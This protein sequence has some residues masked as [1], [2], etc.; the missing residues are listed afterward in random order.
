[1]RLI[2]LALSFAFVSMLNACAPQAPVAT[3]IAWRHDDVED[4]FAEAEASGKP[5]LLYWGAEW[6]PPCNRLKAGLFQDAAFIAQ[7]QGFVPVYLDGDSR[8]AQLYG[9]QFAIQGYATFVILRADRS[10]ITRLAGGGDSDRIS[11]ALAAAQA[12]RATVTE[13]V[14][15]AASAPSQLSA[16]DW[17]LI[18]EYGWEID[19][20]RIVPEDQRAE[21]LQ[22]LAAAAPNPDLSRRFELLA[23]AETDEDQTLTPAQQARA[24]ALLEV[25]LANARETRANRELLIYSG[26]D[27][28]QR[29]AEADRTP[30][31]AALFAALDDV[32]AAND[33]PISDRIDAINAE[34]E[35]FRDN[36]ATP[37]TIAPPALLA[38]VR[39]RAAW[40]DAA[41]Q[42]PYERQSAISSAAYFLE[43]AGDLDGAE[44]L[45]LAELDRSSTP[46]YYMPSLAGIAEKRGDKAG[47]LG[48][49][50]RGYE[51]SIGP[52]SR[53][54]WAVLYADGAIRL[55][56]EDKV[57]IQQAATRAIDELAN[58]DSYHQRTRTRFT[59]LEATLREWA[60]AHNGAD[61]L[62]RLH[63]HMSQVCPAA[64]SDNS[65][66]AACSAWLSAV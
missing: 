31:R 35:V 11:R 28:T 16:E 62:A 30:V 4:A 60:D 64:Q 41:A 9:E 58:P 48:W 37:E 12:S 13:L 45:L 61:V 26:A 23:L 33:L 46:F 54:Q 22:R 17:T 14:A 55:A 50:R 36:A 40:A 24:R 59:R 52:A 25:V 1:M 65:A 15:R 7:T 42:T 8:G 29:L 2:L 18:G 3:E 20:D 57:A 34:V 63:A 32:F 27:L 56:P 47:A 44:R 43:L 53:A 10:E 6:C 38:K 66:R 5:V 19:T 51:T 21:T 49:L 39:A